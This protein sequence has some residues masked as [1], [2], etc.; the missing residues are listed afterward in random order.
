MKKNLKN[1]QC[2]DKPK[3]ESA[4][5]EV[6]CKKVSELCRVKWLVCGN[7]YQWYIS[8]IKQKVENE[9]VYGHLLRVSD[10]TNTQWAYAS[11]EDIQIAEKVHILHCKVEGKWNLNDPQHIKYTL[12]NSDQIIAI[13]SKH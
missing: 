10:M 4:S 12:R 2:N 13:F 5:N 6:I 11:Y 7:E 9:F 1:I 8:Y 3:V